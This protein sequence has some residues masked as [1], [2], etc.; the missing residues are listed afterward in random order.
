[1][2][3][4]APPNWLEPRDYQTTA[5]QTWMRKQGQ[6]VLHMATGTGKTI[7]SLLAASQLAEL[8]G[9]RLALII[10][11]PYQH[12][13]DQWVAEL[14]NFGVTPLRAYKSRKTWTDELASQFTEFATGARDIVAVVT[15]HA[16]FGSDHF[17]SLLTR[18]DGTESLLIADEVHHM[19]AP[20]LRKNLPRSIRA[21]LGLSAT[22]NR[23]YDDDGTEAIMNYFSNGV[24]FE[25]G[26][27]EAIDRGYLCEYYYV[28]H[29]INLTDD[30]SEGYL[31]LSRA[32]GKRMGNVSGDI[33]DADLQEDEQLQQLLFKRARLIGV[34]ENKLSK[35]R[36]L[37]RRSGDIHHTLV[38]CS[39][40]QI[41]A[42]GEAT[43][44]Q[45]NAVTELLG[46]ELGLKTHKF[47]YE[48]DQPTRERLLQDFEDGVLDVLVAIRCLD[49]GVDVPATKT[50]FVLASS[51]NPR[52]FV[53]RRGRI[54]RLHP[55]KD[56]AVIH[57]FI[58]APPSEIRHE[59]SNSTFNLER[60]LV[61]K[62]LQRASTFADCAKNHPDA[63]LTSIPT[64]QESL[65]DLKRDFNLL[66]L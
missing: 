65:A 47:T 64:S 22:P 7:T 39:D 54:L 6:G 41:Q 38:Y 3:Q 34:A 61:Q 62:E 13:V 49:E 53:Q 12:L 16:T 40:G 50:A 19:G 18:L 25:F 55:S 5:V 4:L 32:I 35:L 11:A 51:S 42:E 66:D 37:V 31:A 14:D 33:G 9:D 43:I 63:E 10:A 1:M 59:K 60:R 20:H 28:P 17:Q 58:V 44:R 21:R 26:L 23:W 27:E 30:E 46:K 45:L 2:S 15:T 36:S 24:V 48:E 57:D 29:I 56:H 52:Q 8:Q